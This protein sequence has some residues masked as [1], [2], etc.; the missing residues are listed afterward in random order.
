MRYR[1]MHK[2]LLDQAFFVGK[3]PYGYEIVKVTDTEHKTLKPHPVNAAVVRTIFELYLTEEWSVRRIA[4]WLNEKGVPEP[5]PAK[6]G[7]TRKHAGWNDQAVRRILRKP[8]AIG[9]IMRLG[10]TVLRVDPLVQVDD[11]QRV[12]VIMDKR[13]TRNVVSQETA[14]MT[15]MLFCEHGSPMYRLQGRKVPSNPS[16]LYYYC[17]GCPK[18][19]RTLVALD[20]IDSAVNESIMSIGDEPHFEIT[21]IP[22]DDHTY[23][24]DEVK[25]EIS[26]LDPEHDDYDT[27]LARLRE[28]LRELRALP[29][30]PA[31][32]D[33]KPSGRTIGAVWQSLEDAADKRRFLMKEI[34]AKFHVGREAEGNT[35]VYA[36]TSQYGLI[37]SNVIGN[38]PS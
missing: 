32:L 16:G 3:P 36:E 33:Y 13:G 19:Q 4:E 38:L 23:E 31:K 12:Q 17:K 24:I 8:S 29:S 15:G 9:R 26:L 30:K 10:K 21:I 34:D 11:Y 6:E 1:R 20:Y 27:E 37:R 5:Q 28:K 35:F 14:I 25:Q 2:A 22:G 7:M 18:G